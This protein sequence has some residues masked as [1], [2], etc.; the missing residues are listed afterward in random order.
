MFIWFV[1]M[2]TKTHEIFSLDSKVSDPFHNGWGSKF[3]FI[4]QIRRTM[5]EKKLKASQAWLVNKLH[6]AHAPRGHVSKANLMDA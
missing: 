4:D 5:W 1:V 6:F 3:K 2:I